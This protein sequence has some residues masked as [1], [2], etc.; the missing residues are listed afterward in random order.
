MYLS[1]EKDTAEECALQMQLILSPWRRLPPELLAEIYMFMLCETSSWYY[2]SFPEYAPQILLRVCHTWRA[3]A[4]ATPALW[5]KLSWEIYGQEDIDFIDTGGGQ[6]SYPKAG[7]E[8]MP[9][10][11]GTTRS[12]KRNV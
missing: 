11:G 12:L 9:L 2:H 10:T 7:S 1:K 8:L 5:A 3:L 4:F 6:V